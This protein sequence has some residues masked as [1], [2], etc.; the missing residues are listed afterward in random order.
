MLMMMLQCCAQSGEEVFDLGIW[1]LTFDGSSSSLD[2]MV[3]THNTF[4]EL[5]KLLD[6]P[7]Q[8][9]NVCGIIYESSNMMHHG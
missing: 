6:L 5:M 8:A 9:H 3:S 4:L 1:I 7:I 2:N